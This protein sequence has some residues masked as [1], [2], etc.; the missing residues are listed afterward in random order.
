MKK[1][2]INNEATYLFAIALIAFSV[3]LIAST[4]LGVSMVVAPAY[5]LSLKF[6]FLTFGQW[7]YVLQ[8]LM[9]IAFCI[10]KRKVRLVYF[11][12]FLNCIVYGAVLDLFRTVIPFLNPEITAPGSYA[13]PLR[14]ALLGVGMV[15]TSFAV[16]LFFKAYLYPQVYD[17]F[18]KGV[19]AHFG[20]DRGKFKICYDMS[21]LALSIVLSLVLFGGF[22]GI[23][24]G[25]I[26]MATFNGLI[27][28]IFD[29]ALD[30]Y[31]EFTPA[32]KK[33]AKVYDLE[34]K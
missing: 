31:V 1:I 34:D 5:I 19:S 28:G 27:I 8:G 20:I 11:T 4:D 18:V 10:I 21:S 13:L 3:A 2:K 33:L 22:N 24:I 12:S 7:E 15:L 26:V 29:K 32:F 16:A 9:F 30:K 6:P 23:G 14:I 17:F 25:T